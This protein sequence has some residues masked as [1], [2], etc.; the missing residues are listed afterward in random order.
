MKFYLKINSD[1]NNFAKALPLIADHLVVKNLMTDVSSLVDSNEFNKQSDGVEIVAW[2]LNNT[3]TQPQT[4]IYLVDFHYYLNKNE[5]EKPDWI[6]KTCKLKC[7][8][9]LANWILK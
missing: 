1:E 8:P 2:R 7:C 6:W 5:K 4:P 9:Y 3:M